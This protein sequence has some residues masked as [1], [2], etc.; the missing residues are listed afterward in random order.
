L[1][2]KFFASYREQLGVDEL[3]VPY[4]ESCHTLVQLRETLAEF[5]EGW[6]EINSQENLLIA[7]NQEMVSG[8]Y[9]LEDGDEVAFFPPVTGG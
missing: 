3:E 6:H 5:C 8:D 7:V 2:I 4:K 1:K 9:R